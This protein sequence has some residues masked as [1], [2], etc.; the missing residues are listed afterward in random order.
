M[1]ETVFFNRTTFSS[2]P[3]SFAGYSRKTWW[4]WIMFS[5]AEVTGRLTVVA[6][7]NVLKSRDIDTQNTKIIQ[8]HILEHFII[9]WVRVRVT[10]E[11]VFTSTRDIIRVRSDSLH[12]ITLLGTKLN[13]AVRLFYHGTPLIWPSKGRKN[14]VMWNGLVQ[15]IPPFKWSHGMSCQFWHPTGSCSQCS[16]H[17]YLHFMVVLTRVV[18]ELI[19]LTEID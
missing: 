17:N 9:S 14:V 3:L 13:F 6:W 5:V 1:L 10:T 12:N 2:I 11:R 8:R 7:Q 19:L 16:Q 18:V 4:Y 15:I